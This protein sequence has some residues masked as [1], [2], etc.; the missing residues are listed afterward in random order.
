LQDHLEPNSPALGKLLDERTFTPPSPRTI[1]MGDQHAKER[2]AN[3]FLESFENEEL[4]WKRPIA[5]N[6]FP[7]KR[8]P[9]VRS[10]L[11][12]ALRGTAPFQGPEE[13][14]P[15][16][17]TVVRPRA[18][19]P[20]IAAEQSSQSS[21]S[22]LAPENKLPAPGSGSKKPLFETHDTQWDL[23][24]AFWKATASP[25]TQEL[26]IPGEPNCPEYPVITLD[27]A[28]V[29]IVSGVTTGDTINCL[30]PGFV[31]LPPSSSNAA[32]QS[33]T[34]HRAF[35]KSIPSERQPTSTPEIATHHEHEPCGSETTPDGL[36]Q[37]RRLFSRLMK[38]E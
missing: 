24:G 20:H 13:A 4:V 8:H 28:P 15:E 18:V 14:F 16:M 38:G 1:V 11:G 2:S 6:E 30:G 33:T 17:R 5:L 36:R 9:E 35:P 37:Y 12:Q 22:I 32:G 27:S 23:P 19:D 25:T 21:N 34:T 3:P 26:A 29:T 31:E 10:A 7:A